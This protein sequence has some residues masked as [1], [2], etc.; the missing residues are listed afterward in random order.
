MMVVRLLPHVVYAGPEAHHGAC[1]NVR[2]PQSMSNA[3][4]PL[5]VLCLCA[6]YSSSF[7]N[8]AGGYD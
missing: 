4:Y 7:I 8:L 3:A 1:Y 2:L 6:L 5:N